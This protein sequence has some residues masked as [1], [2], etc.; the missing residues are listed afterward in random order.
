MAARASGVS[1]IGIVPKNDDED[2]EEETT[3]RRERT[4]ESY[5]DTNNGKKYGPSI[6][7]V[8]VDI[9]AG[10]YKLFVSGGRGYYGICKDANC[11]NIVQNDNFQSQAYIDIHTGQF[12]E[13]NRCYA[14][15]IDDAPKFKAPGGVYQSGEYIV[16]VE[17]P[18][19]EYRL[20]ADGGRGYY[21]I[22][23]FAGDGSRDIISNNNFSNAAYVEVR[24]GQI[25][26]L[27]RCTL[28]I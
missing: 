28:K 6:Y 3:S 19:G 9:P 10:K 25:L 2:E 27:N 15:P 22:E 18:A 24:Q 11:D 7:K 12:L 5:A 4:S 26:V 17:I 1:G 23:V 14:M 16:G 13:L 20:V 8:G 21:G